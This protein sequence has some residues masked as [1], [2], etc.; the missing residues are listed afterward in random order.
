MFDRL[1]NPNS[2]DRERLHT[3][4]MLP[5]RWDPRVAGETGL[6]ALSP[7]HVGRFAMWPAGGMSPSTI[8]TS[9]HVGALV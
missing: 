5:S 2:N 9:T 8:S 4:F 7:G 1:L 6:P 3:I